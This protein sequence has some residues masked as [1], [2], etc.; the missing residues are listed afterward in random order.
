MVKFGIIN[1]S[2]ESLLNFHTKKEDNNLII[3]KNKI[4]TEN[5]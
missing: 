4:D 1:S 2:L 5:K 3:K